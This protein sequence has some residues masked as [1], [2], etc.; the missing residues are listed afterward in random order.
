MAEFEAL[1]TRITGLSNHNLL[2]CF[3]SGL[4]EDIKLELFLLKP[5][6]LHEAI[7]MAKLVEDKLTTPRS[8]HLHTTNFRQITPTSSQPTPTNHKP[9]FPIKRLTST[10]MASR[11]A[12]GLCFNCDEAFSPGH[13]CKSKQFLCLL[14]EEPQVLDNDTGELVVTDPLIPTE[15]PETHIPPTD[16]VPS[17][18]LHAFTGQFVHR[19]LKVAGSVNGQSVVALIDGGSTHNFIQTRLAKHLGV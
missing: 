14:A 8:S 7:G 4:R 11:R 2:N 16:P 19:T 3:L 6:T 15:E 17:I 13:R 10:E 9:S 1:S 12:K 5:S 18:S